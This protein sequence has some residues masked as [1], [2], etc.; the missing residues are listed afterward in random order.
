M[1][2][3]LNTISFIFTFIFLT[4]CEQDKINP[5]DNF[6]IEFGSEC[7]WCG[8]EE[9]VIITSSNVEYIRNI[10]CG[11]QKGTTKK[12]RIIETE[13][14]ETITASFD[15]SLFKTLNYSECNVCVD[16]CDEIIKI[17]ENSATHELRYSADDKIEGTQNLRNLLASLLEEMRESD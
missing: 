15:Y 12:A 14:W 10:P 7:G 4:G 1:K 11:E 9:F 6:K 17:T 13:E 8:G 3:L 5:G 2:N 16:G